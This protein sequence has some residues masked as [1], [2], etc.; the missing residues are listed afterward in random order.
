MVDRLVVGVFQ[1]AELVGGDDFLNLC[2]EAGA[3]VGEKV[4]FLLSRDPD[5][6]PAEGGDGLTVSHCSP[7]VVDASVIIT[8]ALEY[9]D[10]L[11]VG[12][13]GV[14]RFVFCSATV[15]GEALFKG[16]AFLGTTAGFGCGPLPG[17]FVL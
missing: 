14:G 4:G 15:T 12:V 1:T 13:L 16:D 10:S 9:F 11:G 7:V 8:H 5:G 3:D 6:L 17:P 2:G